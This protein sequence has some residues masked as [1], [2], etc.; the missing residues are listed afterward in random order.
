[1][2]ALTEFLGQIKF[3]TKIPHVFF[4]DLEGHI[5]FYVIIMFAWT[6]SL[7]KISS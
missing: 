7:L 2:L 1:M 6:E 4:Y 5:S 3:Q